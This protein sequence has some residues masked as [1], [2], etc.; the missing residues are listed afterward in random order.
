MCIAGF[1]FCKKESYAFKKFNSH[2]PAFETKVKH[3]R[4]NKN[5]VTWNQPTRAQK[6]RREVSRLPWDTPF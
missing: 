1:Q 2:R 3:G 4:A 6:E 5:A